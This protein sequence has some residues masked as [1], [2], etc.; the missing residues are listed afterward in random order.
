MAPKTLKNFYRC[1]IERILSGCITAWYGNCT[2]RNHRALQ[3]VMRSTQHITGEKLPTLQDTYS[4]QCHRKAKKIIKVNNHPSHCL[5]TQ[6]SSGR[7]VSSHCAVFGYSA[8]TQNGSDC[9]PTRHLCRENILQLSEFIQEV[10]IEEQSQRCIELSRKHHFKQL[11]GLFQRFQ[12]TL[13]VAKHNN[14]KLTPITLSAITAAKKL[15]GD[16]SCLVAGTDCAKNLLP[17]VSAKLDVAPISDIIEIKSPDTFVRTIYAGPRVCNT[18]EQ[19]APPSKRHHEDQGALQTG[20]AL[21]TVKCN[22]NVKV[23]T[24]RGTSFEPTEAVLHQRKLEATL[25]KIVRPELTRA[26]VVV[27]GGRD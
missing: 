23:F 25:T 11:S 8:S 26:T 21:S 5:F 1:T 22:D 19:G 4:T 2:S 12:S 6:L 13:V 18:T 3:R 24:V 9:S 16:V 10:S 14:D 7:R 17:R 15:G 27:S 20:N